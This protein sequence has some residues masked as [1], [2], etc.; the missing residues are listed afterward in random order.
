MNLHTNYV[1][2]F[3]KK[4]KGLKEFSPQFKSHMYSLHKHYLTIRE[5]KGYINKNVVINYI[6][7]L[8]PAQ[9]MCVL[10]YNMREV[11]K[12]FDTTM[13]EKEMDTD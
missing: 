9:I 1:T 3:I 10:N 12:K 5:S 13:I 4:Q 8:H 2:C 6:N 11:S 7:N